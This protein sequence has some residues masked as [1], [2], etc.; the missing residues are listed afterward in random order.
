MSKEFFSELMNGY[1]SSHG[2]GDFPISL[3]YTE[4]A[5]EVVLDLKQLKHVLISGM[6]QSGKSTMV[7]KMLPSMVQ[8]ADVAIYSTK[9][10]DFIDYHKTAYCCSDLDEMGSLIRRTVGEVERR[11]GRL[12]DDRKEHGMKAQCE[13]KPIVILIDEFQSFVELADQATMIGLKR[14][15]REGAGLNVFLYIITQTP[16]KKV[17]SGGLRD[18]IM[19][20][21]AFKQRDGYGS[22][23]AIG[24][25][26]AEFLELHQCIV[27]NVDKIFKIT[28]FDKST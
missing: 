17:L 7:R 23:M 10:S 12:R 14:I 25:R 6:S 26:E 20:D 5:T 3:G 13:D 9:D 28:R 4:T 11:N 18:N 22:R 19:T 16:T 1:S 15:V 21:I 27:R 24:S 8:Y 2:E